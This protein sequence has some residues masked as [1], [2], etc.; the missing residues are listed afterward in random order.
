[1]DRFACIGTVVGAIANVI[2][3]ALLIPKFSIN[4][5]A[6]ATV[7]SEMMVM[8]SFT[9]FLKKKIK[10]W[11]LLGELPRIL[12]AAIPIVIICTVVNHYVSSAILG[13]VLCVLFSAPAY[14]IALK[15]LHGIFAEEVFK[16]MKGVFE[17]KK[18]KSR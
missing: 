5:A 3:N 16:L 15:L 12:T 14:L 18:S 9:L 7:L 2:L 11:R 17:W 10:V 8:L 6:V 13:C 1:M 4:G